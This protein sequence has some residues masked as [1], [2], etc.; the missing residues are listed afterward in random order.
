VSK[1]DLRIGLEPFEIPCV[2][3]GGKVNPDLPVRI[4]LLDD[5]EVLD[6]GGVIPRIGRPIQTE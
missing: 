2:D 4:L 5:L 6:E 3:I 1:H